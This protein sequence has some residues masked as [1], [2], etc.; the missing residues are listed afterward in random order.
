MT[1]QKAYEK[2]YELLI[3]GTTEGLNHSDYKDV[4]RLSKLKYENDLYKKFWVA[5]MGDINYLLEDLRMDSKIVS[6]IDPECMEYI[7]EHCYLLPLVVANK[8]EK[9]VKPF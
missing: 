1:L 2:Y 9:Y 5:L 8:Q 6:D 4:E 3:K 7:Y